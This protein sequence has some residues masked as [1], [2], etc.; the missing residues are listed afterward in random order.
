M[1]QYRS[2]SHALRHVCGDIFKVW[3]THS[4]FAL[5]SQGRQRDH[6]PD[7]RMDLRYNNVSN[8]KA[9]HPKIPRVGCSARF[10]GYYACKARSRLKRASQGQDIGQCQKN[11]GTQRGTLGN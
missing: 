7:F 6:L 3:G 8:S 10:P 2:A 11:K 9:G 1:G 4:F 5:A